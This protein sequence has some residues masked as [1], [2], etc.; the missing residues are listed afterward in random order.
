[1]KIA[2]LGA[3]SFGTALSIVVSEKAKEVMLWSHSKDIVESIAARNQ[4]S[5][6]MP[7]I[8][9]PLNIKASN[10]IEEVLKGADVVLSVIPT[11]ATREVWEKGK[12]Y[13]PSKCDIVVGSKGIEQKTLKLVSEVMVDILGEERKHSLFFLSGPSFA[14]ELAQKKP[15]AITIAGFD[16][17]GIERMQKLFFTNYFRVYGTT[18]VIGVEVG[19]A[20]KNIMAI[21]TGISD[22]LEMG[23]NARAALITRGLAEMA[24]L[25]KVMGADPMTFMGLAGLGDLVLTCTG[26]LSR[27]RSVGIKL[28]RGKKMDEI[29]STMRMVAEGVASAESAFELAQS[30]GV[31]MPITEAVYKVLYTNINPVEMYDSLM[32]RELKFE[33]ES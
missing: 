9:L 28:A 32:L 19:G 4:N 22:G 20:L 31:P 29:T 17:E 10:D 33:K 23:S 12:K 24:R 13:L 6:Y 15:T 11:Q 21:A 16:K 27:N 7:E 2:V 26:D 3:G 1:M 30:R 25:G 14:R 5:V 8:F 18:D